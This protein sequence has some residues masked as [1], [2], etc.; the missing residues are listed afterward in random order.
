M[1]G[2]KGDCNIVDIWDSKGDWKQISP[3]S[4]VVFIYRT[5]LNKLL[6]EGG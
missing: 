5:P 2:D 1:G 6:E 3:E 4:G